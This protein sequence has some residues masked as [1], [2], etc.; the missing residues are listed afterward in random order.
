MRKALESKQ[1]IKKVLIH[2]KLRHSYHENR[3]KK[4]GWFLPV[5]VKRFAD[6]LQATCQDIDLMEIYINWKKVTC[7]H[8]T[9][10]CCCKQVTFDWE[11]PMRS[12]NVST[13]CPILNMLII[14]QQT[15]SLFLGK[16]YPLF[17]F[18]I[19]WYS[20][21]CI[22]PFHMIWNICRHPN[23]HMIGWNVWYFVI[24]YFLSNLNK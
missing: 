7:W 16:S 13:I 23:L 21:F 1:T 6:R 17:L 18:L 22:F 8:A 5:N 12:W 19:L 24:K 20:Y 10:V 14:Y 2:T 3:N 11:E 9:E 4:R 15:S